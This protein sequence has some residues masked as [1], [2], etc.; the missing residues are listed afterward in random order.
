MHVAD[1][2]M[3][4]FLVSD[5]RLHDDLFAIGGLLSIVIVALVFLVY[6]EAKRG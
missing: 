2:L 1:T 3:N 4:Q 6:L 5:Q